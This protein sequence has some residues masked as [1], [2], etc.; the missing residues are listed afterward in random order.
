MPGG[1]DCGYS[2]AQVKKKVWRYPGVS[3]PWRLQSK[4]HD[5]SVKKS[6]R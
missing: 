5:P 6:K 2:R 4:Y 3:I 1:W